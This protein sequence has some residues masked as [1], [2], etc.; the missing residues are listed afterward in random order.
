MQRVRVAETK[1]ER[2]ACLDLRRLVFVDEQGVGEALEIDGLDDRCVHLFGERAGLAVAAA[3][4]RV[5]TP[6]VMKVERVCVRREHRGAGWGVLIM[7]EAERV[8][9][10]RGVKQ[11]VLA[12]QAEVISFYRRLGYV[13]EGPMFVE[14]G[15][16]HQMMRKK[17][18]EVGGR[19]DS[20]PQT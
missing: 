5:V 11:L 15:I 7:R 16:D 6:G 2:T 4:L 8:A 17:L 12:A 19:D 1:S 3:R 13:G 9:Q 14:A 20:A 18:G 10:A